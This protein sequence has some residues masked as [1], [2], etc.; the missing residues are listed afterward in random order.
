MPEPTPTPSLPSTEGEVEER[1]KEE[2]GKLTA[3]AAEE[4]SNIVGNISIEGMSNRWGGATEE[5]T[6][7][8]TEVRVRNDNDIPLYVRRISFVMDMNN[9]TMVTGE[10]QDKIL[11]R[12]KSVTKVSVES[13]MDN[14]RIPEWWVS[15]IRNGEK[16]LVEINVEITLEEIMGI[17]VSIPPCYGRSKITVSVRGKEIPMACIPTINKTIETNILGK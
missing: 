13:V 12:S 1:V 7:I 14:T 16:T 6:V 15:H 4:F 2:V 11:L 9:I 5:S 8:K 10:S 17:P 3:E